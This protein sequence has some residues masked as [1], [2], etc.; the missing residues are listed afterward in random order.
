MGQLLRGLYTGA[1]G[2]LVGLHEMD[3]VA[4]NLANASTVGFR[5]ADTVQRAFPDLLIQK[6]EKRGLGPETSSTSIGGLGLGATIDGTYTD[7]SPGALR[8][9]ENPLDMAL[10]E[11]DVFFTVNTADGRRYTRNGA[12][13]LDPNGELVTSN[14]DQVLGMRGP[15]RIRGGKVDIDADG[16]VY[17]DDVVVD[18]LLITT[19]AAPDMLQRGAAQCFVALPEAGVF[20][21]AEFTVAQ[22]NLEQSNVNVVKELVKMINVQRAYEAN[23]KAVRAADDTLGK[24]VNE[25]NV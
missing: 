16:F 23:Q 3:V 18:R 22:G 20:P 8:P 2:M 12:F 14:G 19:F 24:L 7:F 4:N 17:V 10:L 5:T 21:A 11:P 13:Q 1:S 6:V 15:I 25:L 9:T